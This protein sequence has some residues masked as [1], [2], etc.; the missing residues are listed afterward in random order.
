V[1]RGSTASTHRISTMAAL[2]LAAVVTHYNTIL[3]PSLTAPEQADLVEFL[4]PQ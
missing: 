2:T 3:D 1:G 4:K